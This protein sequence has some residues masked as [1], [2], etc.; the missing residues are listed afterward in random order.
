MLQNHPEVN[1][2]DQVIGWQP[3]YSTHQ[4]QPVR[5]Q[6][7]QPSFAMGLA[8]AAFVGAILLSGSLLWNKAQKTDAEVSF[9]VHQAVNLER[10]RVSQCLAGNSKQGK[11]QLFQTTGN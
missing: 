6:S 11:R 5:S 2:N 9:E 4:N 1:R 3:V 8:A 7:S 10:E